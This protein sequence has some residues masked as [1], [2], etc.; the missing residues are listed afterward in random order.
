VNDFIKFLHSI[1][2]SVSDT[3]NEIS[4]GIVRVDE[5]GITNKTIIAQHSDETS[6][7]VVAITQMSAAADSVATSASESESFTQKMR[8]DAM[9]S[10]ET[11][12]VAS[13]SVQELLGE[14]DEASNNVESMQKSTRQIAE[15]LK[16][17]GAIA[18]QTN[19][20]ALNAAIEAARAGEQGRGFAVVADEVRAL[21]AKTQNSTS[22]INDVISTLELGVDTVVSAMGRTKERCHEAAENTQKVTQK[23][24]NMNESITSLNELSSHIAGSADEQKSVSEEINKIMVHIQSI[25]GEISTNADSGAINAKSLSSANSQLVKLVGQFRL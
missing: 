14:V 3:S 1:M 4:D 12:L 18:D 9:D 16:I 25:V 23:I 15:V 5:H 17:I 2:I 8:E 6:Q 13:N 24:D 19:L 7:A 11:V 10:K 22:E 21:A 20:L